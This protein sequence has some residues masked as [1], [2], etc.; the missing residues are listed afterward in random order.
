[1]IIGGEK[2]RFTSE[3]RP[4][5]H[6]YTVENA[7]FWKNWWGSVFCWRG[8]GRGFARG[9]GGFF[10]DV[11][12]AGWT[13]IFGWG[14]ACGRDLDAGTTGASRA[15]RTF[16]LGWLEPKERAVS[17]NHSILGFYELP[18][19]G[20]GVN[21]LRFPRRS[22]ACLGLGVNCPFGAVDLFCGATGVWG[23]EA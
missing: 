16:G 4:F 9:W 18:L 1:M 6:K 14:F 12:V 23:N 2:M 3:K 7:D 13:D 17:A 11:N 5:L 15:G 21:W 19:Q 8:L 10:G 22:G 20:A